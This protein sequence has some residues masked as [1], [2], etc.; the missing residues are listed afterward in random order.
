MENRQAQPLGKVVVLTKNN[1]LNYSA[2]F[3]QRDFINALRARQEVSLFGP[4]HDQFR[5][6][7]T[8][9]DLSAKVGFKPETIITGHMW[10]ADNPTDPISPAPELDLKRFGGLKIGI[11][12]KE[13][14]RLHEK[15]QWFDDN[16][17][18]LLLSHNP[19]MLQT[20]CRTPVVFWPFG[21]SPD[22]CAL[23][24]SRKPI[25]LGFTGLLRNPTFG[26]QQS[27]FR[28][29]VMRD[30]FHCWRDVPISK[31][32]RW[33]SLNIAWRSWSG[34]RLSYLVSS[35]VASRSKLS[36][37]EYRTEMAQSK[38][39]INSLSPSGIISTR[40]F[41]NALCESLIF[42]EPGF[43]LDLVFSEEEIEYVSSP[44][45][46]FEKARWFADNESE[47]VRKVQ[48]TREKIL[49]G[50]LWSHRI[51]QLLSLAGIN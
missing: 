44:D 46:L 5:E 45:E 6:S 50:H 9:V 31:R 17:F 26:S 7:D 33:R 14:S 35:R 11:L 16:G 40:Y 19:R 10:L 24:P 39:W 30:I 36:P 37:L 1:Y 32:A 48:R 34:D 28:I 29:K 15:L 2:A 3:Y 13:Y 38:S 23:P 4:G 18:D 41:E 8:W 25:D 20:E 43:G 21:V 27:D 22:F 47:R 12:N 42:T 51:E 49:N